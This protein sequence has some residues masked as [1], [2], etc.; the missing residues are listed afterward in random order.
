MNH[1]EEVPEKEC[2]GCD[3]S[4]PATSEFFNISAKGVYGL[5]SWCKACH[6]ENYR[7]RCP[8]K[9]PPPVPDVFG[10]NLRGAA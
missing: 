2:T 8:V 7:A 6:N 1:E 9:P 4:W 5:H 3:E 10:V